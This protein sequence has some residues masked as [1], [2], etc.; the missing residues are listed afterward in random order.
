LLW[1]PLAGNAIFSVSQAII[2]FIFFPGHVQAAV[3]HLVSLYESV[4][5]FAV[6]QSVVNQF[7]TRVSKLS[8][9]ERFSP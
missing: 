6:N 9:D 1:A 5:Q 8:L 3:K 2:G 4:N 7:A